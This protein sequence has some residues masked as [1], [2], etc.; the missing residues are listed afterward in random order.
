MKD[1]YLDPAERRFIICE[2]GAEDEPDEDLESTDDPIYMR[3]RLRELSQNKSAR[4][5]VWD[6]A[7]QEY[8]YL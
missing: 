1:T 5:R 7:R 6:G 4:F 2:Y 3:Q 8:I